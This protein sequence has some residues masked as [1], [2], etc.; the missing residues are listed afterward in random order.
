MPRNKSKVVPKGKGPIPQNAYVMLCGITLKDFRRIRSEAAD[1][2]FDK[3][4]E[5][6]P[7]N[8]EEM[9]A[10][11]QR[12]ASLEH[13][14]RQPCLAM[15][16]CV[17]ADTKTRER[18][19]GAAT[20]VQAMHWDSF[21]ANRVQAGPTCLTSFGVK[22][23]PRA[24]PCR[25]DVLVENGTAAPKSCLSPSEMRTS[26]AVG[27]LLPTDKTSTATRT[28]FHQLP[29]WFCLT[30]ETNS[31]TSIPYASYYSI[32]GWINNQQPSSGRGS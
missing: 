6:K 11:G 25:D 8:L 26:T 4:F 14:A 16:A 13:D 2:V 5:Q 1:K 20:A 17:P 22:A 31:R 7:E 30:K 10:T 21:S 3:H 27:R 9:R 12:V 32:F 29:L 15:D 23:E 28:T 24:L 19:E 18:T